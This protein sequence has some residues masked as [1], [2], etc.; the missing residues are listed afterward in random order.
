M[1]LLTLGITLLIVV[2]LYTI[3]R[4]RQ[5]FYAR[6]E[7]TKQV[8]LYLKDNEFPEPIE[9]V[10]QN[11][12]IDT[13]RHF[14][15][16]EMIF[17]IIIWKF[18]PSLSGLTNKA[19]DETIKQRMS[20]LDD[21]DSNQAMN[22]IQIIGQYLFINI[23]LS[24]ISYIFIAVATLIFIITPSLLIITAKGKIGGLVSELKELQIIRLYAMHA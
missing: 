18:F 6:E 22:L 17:S 12:Y 21:L 3:W 19:D 16:W 15:P 20:S 8:N 24:P 23:K 2:P 5:A 14:N 7:L 11:A 9:K 10:I 4:T 1:N 13:L